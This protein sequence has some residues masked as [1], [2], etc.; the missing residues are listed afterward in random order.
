MV[1]S[2]QI[3]NDTTLITVNVFFELCIKKRIPITKNTICA[4]R[5]GMV[6]SSTKTPTKTWS[7]W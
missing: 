4:K 5:K 7:I 2:V 3:A 6:N 1:I